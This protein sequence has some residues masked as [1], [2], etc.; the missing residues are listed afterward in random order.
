DHVIDGRHDDIEAAAKRFAPDGVDAVL[1]FFGGP[2]LT[3]CLHA[4]RRGGRL[5]YPRGVEPEPRKRRG[6]TIK[7]YDG[8][9]GATQSARLA[10]ALDD[11]H[12]EFPIAAVYGLAEAARAQA[13]VE[14][15]HVLGKTVL[16]IGTHE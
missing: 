5:A 11:G 4:V 13:Q 9:T 12:I 2:T 8:E 10:R 3:R 1:A 16:R 7:E 15:G 6:L 14:R